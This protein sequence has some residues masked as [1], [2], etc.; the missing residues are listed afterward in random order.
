MRI[1]VFSVLL[2]CTSGAYTQT[3]ASKDKNG[4]ESGVP[5]LL[6]NN[7]EF[8]I[9]DSIVLTEEILQKIDFVKYAD[10][11]TNFEDIT[12]TDDSSG[13]TFILYSRNQAMRNRM[14][15][16]IALPELFDN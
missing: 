2:M 5:L 11:R 3:L 15:S 8:K 14:A 13:L 10:L 7:I 9:L 16:K 4:Q 6:H 12:I 1:I